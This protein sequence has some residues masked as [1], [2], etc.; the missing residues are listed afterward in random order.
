M[1]LQ[2][3]RSAGH[4]PGGAEAPQPG[5]RFAR[6]TALAR[7]ADHRLPQLL[8]RRAAVAHQPRAPAIHGFRKGDG[9]RA[10]LRHTDPTR[11]RRA[12]EGALPLPWRPCS[13][14]GFADHT[15]TRVSRSR[16]LSIGWATGQ[17]PDHR[18]GRIEGVAPLLQHPQAHPDHQRRAGA[19]H[20]SQGKPRGAA[21]QKPHAA[22]HP[23]GS[24]NRRDV[25]G[26]DLNC[27]DPIAGRGA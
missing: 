5:D 7:A 27:C 11:W 15:S 14:C 8:P 9:E 25:L 12:P 18:H 21:I 3:W 4:Q 6:R 24:I 22:G 2:P 20:G 26:S 19:G 17:H 23:G 10:V 1:L 13:R 16:S